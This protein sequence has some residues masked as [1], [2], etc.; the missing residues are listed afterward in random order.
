MDP[1]R[2]VLVVVSA[3]TQNDVLYEY[4]ARLAREE[5]ARTLLIDYHES[6]PPGWVSEGRSRAS[7]ADLLRGSVS[8]REVV[9]QSEVSYRFHVVSGMNG[10]PDAPFAISPT[11]LAEGY[12]AVMVLTPLHTRHAE[13]WLDRAGAVLL[14]C[15]PE[16]ADHEAVRQSLSRLRERGIV[17]QLLVDCRGADE[18][19][20]NR[21]AN[22]VAARLGLR[23]WAILEQQESMRADGGPTADA[24]AR[25]RAIKQIDDAARQRDE[26]PSEVESASTV[27][28]GSPYSAI[29]RMELNRALDQMEAAR[30][31]FAALREQESGLVAEKE[32]AEQEVIALQGEPLLQDG[33]S[34][35]PRYLERFGALYQVME[36]H[37][38]FCEQN[39]LPERQDEVATREQAVRRLLGL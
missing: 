39:R 35:N 21:E 17:P 23:L 16:A 6:V 19:A 26:A 10:A 11:V 25:G 30:A 20:I 28:A 32:R 31:Q 4:G 9:V 5:G 18:A 33:G 2:A 3:L 27:E 13:E 14:A 37:R 7:L 15:T 12:E 29:D 24:G 1:K 38:H 22:D 34:I 8:L 36:G